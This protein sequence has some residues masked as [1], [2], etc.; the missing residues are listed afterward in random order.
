[1][2]EETTNNLN[3]YL[4]SNEMSNEHINIIWD[5][6]VNFNYNQPDFDE[7]NNLPNYINH[8]KYEQKQQMDF[9][10]YFSQILDILEKQEQYIINISEEI[11]YIKD[12]IDKLENK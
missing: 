2:I 5:R 11:K 8:K 1:M 7:H 3:S 10:L 9:S 12:K 4:K 6:M